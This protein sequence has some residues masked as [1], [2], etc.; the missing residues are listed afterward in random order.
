MQ[1]TE[2]Y[3]AGPAPEDIIRF[4]FSSETRNSWFV[5]S[6]AFD[7]AVR[8]RFG[9][10]AGRA[11]SGD[12]DDW[13]RT[14]EGSLALLLLLDQV[15]RNIYRRTAQAF[16]SDD[17]ALTL[18]KNAVSAGFDRSFGKDERLFFYLPFE[19]AEDRAAQDLSVRLIEALGDDEY[20]DYARRHREIIYR[21]GRFPHRNEQLG[22]T[23]TEAE[24]EYLKPP[25]SSF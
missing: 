3:G 9:A 20:T 16:Q 21:F 13:A 4:W 12:L 17:K 15:P 7:A 6:E 23:S 14:P 1:V 2:A 18:A 24:I 25:G 8:E 19:H 11:R 22:R 5:A 10:L